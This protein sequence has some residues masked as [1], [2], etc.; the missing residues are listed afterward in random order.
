MKTIYRRL[1]L[2]NII[3]GEGVNPKILVEEAAHLVNKDQTKKVCLSCCVR[4]KIGLHL[5]YYQGSSRRESCK[6][7][8]K[9]G[10]RSALSHCRV[11]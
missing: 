6:S 2:R 10:S 7:S 9:L 8:R 3:A 1:R 11:G 4:I 5:L